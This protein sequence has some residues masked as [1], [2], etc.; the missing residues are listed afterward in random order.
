M[1]SQI[2]GNSKASQTF[3]L[4]E[5]QETQTS[6]DGVESVQEVANFFVEEI[7]R[8]PKK[9]LKELITTCAS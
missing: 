2:K 5:N 4:T 7:L 3:N 6:N 9:N 8:K 1:S